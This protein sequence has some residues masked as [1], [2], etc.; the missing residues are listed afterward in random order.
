M[1]KVEPLPKGWMQY[2][3][4]VAV[5]SMFLYFFAAS[6]YLWTSTLIAGHLSRSLDSLVSIELIKGTTFMAASALLFGLIVWAFLRRL[7]AKHAK[8]GV[9]EKA[10]VT[11]DQ[12]ALIGQFAAGVA[13]D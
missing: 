3:G 13:H 5:T 9:I 2:P 12:R 11:A 8:I 6:G 1:R 7:S 4:T 10:L